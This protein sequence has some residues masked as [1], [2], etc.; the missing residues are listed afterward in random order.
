MSLGKLVLWFILGQ[1]NCLSTED[2]DGRYVWSREHL[3]RTIDGL[4]GCWIIWSGLPHDQ[5]WAL[6]SLVNRLCTGFIALAVSGQ[7]LREAQFVVWRHE[8]GRSMFPGQER[9]VLLFRWGNT[10]DVVSDQVPP[11]VGL[12]NVS[13]TLP[14]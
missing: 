1:G 12:L 9:P 11:Y 14:G 6:N 13:A 3:D 2:E 4:Y 10:Q 7:D 8:S 5:D